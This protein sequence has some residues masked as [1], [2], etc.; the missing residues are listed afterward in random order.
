MARLLWVRH[1]AGRTAT[2]H[3]SHTS[4]RETEAAGCFLQLSGLDSTIPTPGPGLQAPL[5][6]TEG[7]SEM[8]D[9]GAV[10]GH[11]QPWWRGT[12][13]S[14]PSPGCR[15][16]WTEAT[17]VG[18]DCGD[19][20]SHPPAVTRTLA[21]QALGPM[22]QT[23]D[24]CLWLAR[25][26]GPSLP[27]APAASCHLFLEFMLPPQPSPSAVSPCPVPGC[28]LSF[29]VPPAQ[30]LRHL[31]FRGSHGPGTEAGQGQSLWAKRTCL[32]PDG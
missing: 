5:A 18:P 7:R 23:R 13:A 14:P 9:P 12:S 17:A 20:T 28:A 3:L 22:S 21:P 2:S 11:S 15:P 16:H 10:P 4:E 26:S 19:T 27:S 31:Q 29:P 32:P 6:R 24:S 25:S 8:P 30:R 1:T